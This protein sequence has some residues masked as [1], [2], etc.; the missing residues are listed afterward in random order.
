MRIE[1]YA[2][3]KTGLNAIVIPSSVAQLG[4]GCFSNCAQLQSVTSE[5]G[6]QLRHIGKDAFKGTLVSRVL[7]LKRCSVV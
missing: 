1:D 3:S 7:P 4:E 2:F 5:R 6:S